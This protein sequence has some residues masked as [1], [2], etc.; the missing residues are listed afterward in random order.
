MSRNLNSTTCDFCGHD[1]EL[2]ENPRP[3]T[4]KDTGIRIFKKF[5]G[6]LV[7]DAECPMCFA[8]YLAWVDEATM[9][10]NKHH[11]RSPNRYGGIV[12]LSF[13]KSFNDEPHE[14]DLP[15]YE[16]QQVISWHR[17][18]RLTDKRR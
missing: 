13:R 11:H 6:M 4:V 10:G 18:A 2:N 16:V 12:D 8:K 14:E 15:A 1:V 7:A 9:V 3:I 17:I 5:E